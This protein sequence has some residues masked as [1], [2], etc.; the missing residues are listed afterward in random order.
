MK[1]L[2]LM[3][4]NRIILKHYSEIETQIPI[5]K[6]ITYI[7]NTLCN[8]V[9]FRMFSH[10]SSVEK[11]FAFANKIVYALSCQKAQDNLRKESEQNKAGTHRRMKNRLPGSSTE[12]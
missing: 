5:I 10:N 1:E 6:A 2:Y 9:I 4:I 12:T 11:I 7:L 3:I 8:I